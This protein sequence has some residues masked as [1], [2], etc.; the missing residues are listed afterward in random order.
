MHMD[1]LPWST[2]PAGSRN[3]PACGNQYLG[4]EL[5]LQLACSSSV[6]LVFYKSHFDL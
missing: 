4:N 2:C 3:V 6:L 5:W 1:V